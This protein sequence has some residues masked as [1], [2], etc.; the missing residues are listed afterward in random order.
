MQIGLSLSFS[1]ISIVSRF[2]K[3][4]LDSI[5]LESINVNVLQM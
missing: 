4:Q 5:E 2:A 1:F 3:S